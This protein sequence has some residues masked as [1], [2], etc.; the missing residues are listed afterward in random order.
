MRQ[1]GICD[2]TAL[3]LQEKDDPSKKNFFTEIVAS[4]S[5]ACFSKNGRYLLNHNKKH[6]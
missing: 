5:E 3:V 1:T 6:K 2:N 4:I